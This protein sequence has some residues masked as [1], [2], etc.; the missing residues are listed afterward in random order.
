MPNED[1]EISG[2]DYA[3]AI[4]PAFSAA[5]N[6]VFDPPAGDPAG[7]STG[8]TD[9]AATGDPAPAV[10]DQGTGAEE[11][12]AGTPT[13]GTDAAADLAGADTSESG[14]PAGA[15]AGPQ[16][17]DANVPVG[18]QQASAVAYADVIPF[19]AQSSKAIEESA[20]R[21]FKAQATRELFE[22]LDDKYTK[23]L[24]KHPR[25]LVGDTVP[26]LKGGDGEIRIHDSADAKEWQEAAQSLIQADIESRVK[27]KEEEVAPVMSA[28]QDSILLFQ[29]NADLMP[30]TKEFDLELANEFASLVK[31]F[32]FRIDGKL[33]GYH[34]D[35]QP[36]LN[37]LRVR[38]ATQRGASKATQTQQQAAKQQQA[39]NQ[40]RNDA[41][42]FDAPQAGIT[43]KAGS[44]G[45][46]EDDYGTF[47]NGVGMKGM[48]V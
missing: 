5:W 36:I 11:E 18:D 7:E 25:L 17:G 8:E 39:A 3:S 30:G 32:E 9:P 20:A 19:M 27:V 4:D 12:P 37:Q 44:S 23:A 6:D 1:E 40:S 28:I 21:S 14:E 2:G 33:F 48:T 47:F 35:V 31:S 13:G 24:N 10:E 41:G 38:L 46:P 22:T 15:P 34:A 29:N 43:S 42:Q 45:E 16:P 26:D